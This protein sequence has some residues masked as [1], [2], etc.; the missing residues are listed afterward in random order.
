MIFFLVN[1]YILEW[2]G[3]LF[4]W[5]YLFIYLSVSC[6]LLVPW[7][8]IEPV[9]LA[10]VAWSL[11]HWTRVGSREVGKSGKPQLLYFLMVEKKSK[12]EYTFVNMTMIKTQ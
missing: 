6:Q 2:D 8:G 11:N 12:D 5:F 3:G 10:V 7:L 1:F 9:P 4:F